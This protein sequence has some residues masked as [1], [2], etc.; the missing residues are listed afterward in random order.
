[1]SQYT[2]LPEVRIWVKWKF[3]GKCLGSFSAVLLT[4]MGKTRT[5]L[6][7]HLATWTHVFKLHNLPGCNWKIKLFYLFSDLF[8]FF[9]VL[10]FFA[11]LYAVSSKINETSSDFIWTFMTLQSVVFIYHSLSIIVKQCV[12]VYTISQV[13][14]NACNQVRKWK[15][16]LFCRINANAGRHTIKRHSPLFRWTRSILN[17][18]A[19]RW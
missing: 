11:T 6:T 15:D 9:L 1:M 19:I 8:L 16:S 13:S 12:Q 18:R 14:K 5:C 17:C 4:C 10:I 7:F 2:W 3:R